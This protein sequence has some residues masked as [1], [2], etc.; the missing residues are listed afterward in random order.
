MTTPAWV[1]FGCAFAFA[2]VDW[3]AVAAARKPLE[4]VCK[5]AAA[6]TFFACALALDP[7]H[8]D[9]RAWFAVALVLC[10][11][12]DTF[13]MLPGDRFVPGLGAFLVAQ[14][15]FT[16]GFALAGTDTTRLA[17]GI[18]VVLA[19]ALPLVIRTVRALQDAG[20][21]ELV[22]PVVVYVAAISAMVAT[23][24]ASGIAVGIAG[25][26]LFFASDALIA[27][28]RFVT[29]R[30]WSLLAIIVT[31]H[32]ALGGLVLSLTA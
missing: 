16:V 17:I 26:A 5:P 10:A 11:I 21:R 3:Y 1:L 13:L 28:Q 31:Y 18:A 27:E 23:A 25:A 9:T 29:P 15:C 7:T 22:P 14:L 20:R 8:S 24:I 19:V 4:Y 32:L 2:A 30:S 6:L 12:G